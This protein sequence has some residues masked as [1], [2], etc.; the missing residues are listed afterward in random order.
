MIK[1]KIENK[2]LLSPD[3]PLVQKNKNRCWKCN[4][5]VDLTASDCKCGY[6]FC[7]AHR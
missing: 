2:D 1:D 6:R 5:K 7:N 4:K 3:D